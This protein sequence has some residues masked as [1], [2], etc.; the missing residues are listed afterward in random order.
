MNI[1]IIADFHFNAWRKSNSFFHHIEN[2]ID[3]FIE[4]CNKRNVEYI[5]VA[6]DTFHSKNEVAAEMLIRIN[7][8]IDKLR[9]DRK[10]FLITGN[11]DT[12]KKQ[13]TEKNLLDIYKYFENVYVINEYSNITFDNVTV[14]MLPH[15]NNVIKEIDKI[16]IVPENKNIFIS[17]FGVNGFTMLQSEL[18][19]IK[20]Y[21]DSISPNLL[22]KF[23]WVFLGHYHAYQTQY[24]IT[25][26][27]SPFQSRHGDEFGKHGFVF[28]DTDKIKYDFVENVYSPQY[29]TMVLNKKTIK[30]I[31]KKENKFLRL[32]IQEFINRDILHKIFQHLKSKNNMIKICSDFTK[33]LT[34]DKL[35]TVDG[36]EEIVY[37]TPEDII[38]GFV[39][40]I[41]DD[42]IPKGVTKE[43]LL[44]AIFND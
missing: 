17:H 18:N 33:T 40:K 39:K 10:V 36:W 28:V 7:S 3:F 34:I 23:D 8:I 20:S 9:C 11:H 13:E 22:K 44:G 31:L 30:D 5:F 37:E 32:I 25:Y 41:P 14:H 21:E 24:N 2:A 29:E 4:E 1:G 15:K 12:F 26:V 6:G 38:T 35:A 27:S 19:D 42:E 16:K 43:E